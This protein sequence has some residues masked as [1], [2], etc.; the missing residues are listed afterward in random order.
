MS[1]LLSNE[2]VFC[3]SMGNGGVKQIATK[4][5]VLSCLSYYHKRLISFIIAGTLTV[6]LCNHTALHNVSIFHVQCCQQLNE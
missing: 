5:I 1:V 3:Q 2:D 4:L 6:Y